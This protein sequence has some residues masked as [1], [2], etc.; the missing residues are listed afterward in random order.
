MHEQD[1]SPA[2][3]FVGAVS[4]AFFVLTMLVAGYVLAPSPR[5]RGS[6][7]GNWF[8]Y[9]LLCWLGLAIIVVGKAFLDSKKANVIS[10]V[11]CAVGVVVMAFFAAKID[12]IDDMVL[13]VKI[14]IIIL[15]IAFFVI[16]I[17]TLRG[18]RLPGRTK[19]R[20]LIRQRR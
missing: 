14:S 5:K 11:V 19:G 2:L 9:L 10:L 13:P 17:H 4:S 16:L 20:R 18:L 12:N 8:I 3:L 6:I 7:G 15:G 1:F